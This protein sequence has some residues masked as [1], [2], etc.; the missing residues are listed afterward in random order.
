MYYICIKY[1]CLDMLCTLFDNKAKDMGNLHL[2]VMAARSNAR[3]LSRE[4]C[5]RLEIFEKGL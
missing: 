3:A 4:F 1:I 5:M 2:G